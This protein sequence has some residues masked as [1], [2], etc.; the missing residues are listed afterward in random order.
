MTESGIIEV[1]SFKYHVVKGSIIRDVKSVLNDI[2][3]KLLKQTF[4]TKTIIPS[5]K[6]TQ[7]K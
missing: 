2:I 5:F 1:E 6:M 7:V 4:S 3:N